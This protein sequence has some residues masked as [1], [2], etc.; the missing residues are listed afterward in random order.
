MPGYGSRYWSERTADNRRRSYPVFRGQ[1]T[2]DAVVIGGG[3]TGATAAYVLA[4]AKLNVVLLEA[5][6]LAGG[7]T[8]GSLG[9]ILPEPDASFRSVE[10]L[11]GR[12]AARTAWTDAQRSAREFAAALKMLP[13]KSDLTSAALVINA[14]TPDD[15]AAL[16]KEQAARRAASVGA[17]WATP[18]SVHKEIG[19]ESLGG[20]RLADSFT[21][22]PVRATLGLAGAAETHGARIFE[23][24]TVRK[25][26][27][28][29]KYA[30]VLLSG[31]S[32]RTKLIVVATG[33]PGTLFGQLR[34][35]VRR[36]TGYVVVTEPW[37]AAM[38][39]EAGGRMGV[40]TEPGDNRPFARWLTDDRILY[41]GARSATPP[42]RLRDQSVVQRTAQLM[43][44]LSLRYPAISGLPAR[45]GWDIP[46]VTTPDGLPWIGPHRNYPF[47]FFAMALGWHGAGLGWL[48]ARAALRQ[49]RGERRREDDAFGFVRHL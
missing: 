13:T 2:A 26:R 25:T 14:R 33:E 6:R 28:T 29:R 19:G 35:H 48:A 45:W 12:W 39:R 4:S 5:N 40:L 18:A 37:S 10:S 49:A 17:P 36:E 21:V 23:R 42:A 31:A 24:S 16:R 38:R 44:E 32:I 3:L 27:F 1:Q 20:L 11:A 46:V 34:R 41:A 43:Y 47:H 22:D 8:A 30:D 7:A 15:L 9:V